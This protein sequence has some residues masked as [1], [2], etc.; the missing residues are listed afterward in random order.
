[1]PSAKI[2]E[3][4]KAEVSK[5]SEAFKKAQTLVVADYRGLTVAEDTEMRKAMREAGVEYHV[6]K[7]TMAYLAAKEAGLEGLEEVFKGPTAV[8]FSSEDAVQPAK[9]LKDFAKKF[10]QLE[11]KGGATE[12]QVVSLDV[13][14][15]LASIPSRETLLTQLVFTLNSPIAGLARALNEISKLDGSAVASE[16][17]AAEEAPAAQE[18]AAEETAE[19]AAE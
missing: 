12:G 6:I 19:P 5:W 2:L 4:K 7:N 14:E 10:K 15:R 11:I 3:V 17:V 16:E 18:A 13:I 8:A 9:M 1:M